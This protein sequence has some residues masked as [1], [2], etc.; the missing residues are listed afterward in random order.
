MTDKI[1]SLSKLLDDFQSI[2]TP[3]YTRPTFLNILGK[4]RDEN[5]IS[6][7]LAF[8]FDS[9]QVHELGTL[10]FDSYLECL[11]EN[12]STKKNETTNVGR[13]IVTATGKRID[14]VV[15]SRDIILI[16]ENKIFHSLNNDLLEYSLHA[17]RLNRKKEVKLSVL[18]IFETEE[19]EHGFINVTYNTF[20]NK[21]KA[22]LIREYSNV[23][24]EY[25]VLLHDLFETIKSLNT[26]TMTDETYR[27]FFIE[28][29]ED[30]NTLLEEKN[31]LDSEITNRAHYIKNSIQQVNNV[32]TFVWA[33]SVVVNEMKFDNGL[34]LKADC[35]LTMEGYYIHVF[36]QRH[37]NNDI[38]KDALELIPYFQDSTDWHYWSELHDYDY[39]IENM[40]KL[41]NE[42]IIKT[43][44]AFI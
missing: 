21:I 42:T 16:I 20:F 30:I 28:R 13:E 3:T 10:F 6:N 7:I 37:G 33:G 9:N 18:S 39:P 23:K 19:C 24:N 11:D 29:Q 36:I 34:L 25:S 1:N 27:K 2:Y 38:Y 35:V 31:K 41:M 22:S 32:N 43:F 44:S 14:I 8:F 15:E 26:N 40:V 12:K 4:P 17:R 5:I